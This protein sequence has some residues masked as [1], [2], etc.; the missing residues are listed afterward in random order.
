MHLIFPVLWSK[1]RGSPYLFRIT[2][3]GDRNVVAS[4]ENVNQQ[5]GRVQES[6]TASLLSFLRELNIGDD[7]IRE[8]EDAVKAEPRITE[9]GFGPKVQ[10]WMGRMTSKAASGA[11]NVSLDIAIKSLIL[12]LSDYYG[13]D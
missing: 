4:G 2:I 1:D 3:Y 11:W 9:G 12:A 13:I 6:D 10:A 8:I 5:V 7:D